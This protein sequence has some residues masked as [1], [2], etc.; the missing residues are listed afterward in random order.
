MDDFD[1]IIVGAGSAGCVLANRLTADPATPCSSSRPAAA[2]ATPWCTIPLGM[3]KLHEHR[4]HNW[5]YRDRAR[6]RARR[7]PHLGTRGKVLGGSLVDQRHD[8]YA[9]QSRRLRPLG[10]DRAQPGWSYAEVL[11]YFERAETQEKRAPLAGAAAMARS[12]PNSACTTSIRF[13]ARGSKPGTRGR[14]S[15]HIADDN[16]GDSHVGIGYSQ[17]TI[18]DGRRPT[19]AKRLPATRRGAART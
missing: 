14:P 12:A 19:V 4:I 3:G 11:P 5:D 8:L 7:P 6:A 10:A 1:Y 9:R 13:A 17:H 16:G 2:T 18:G 15:G